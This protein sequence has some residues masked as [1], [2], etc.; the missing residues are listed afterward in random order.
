M[1]DDRGTHEAAISAAQAVDFA[2]SDVGNEA[3]VQLG[4]AVYQFVHLAMESGMSPEAA[5]S[6]CIGAASSA[7]TYILLNEVKG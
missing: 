6:S 2:G 1:E 5:V 4:Q 3:V 7:T